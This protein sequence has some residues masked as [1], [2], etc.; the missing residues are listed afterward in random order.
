MGRMSMGLMTKRTIRTSNNLRDFRVRVAGR[1]TRSP[2]RDDYGDPSVRI[3]ARWRKRRGA[4]RAARLCSARSSY[5]PFF[6]SQAFIC[7]ISFS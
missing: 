1:F 6:S 3:N 2:S 7:A 5:L 4:S